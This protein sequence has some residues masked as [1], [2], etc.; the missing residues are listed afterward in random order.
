MSSLNQITDAALAAC[1]QCVRGTPHCPGTRGCKQA[2]RGLGPCEW[3]GLSSKPLDSHWEEAQS[4]GACTLLAACSHCISSCHSSNVWASFSIAN[5]LT[6][7]QHVLDS[8]SR[9][10]RQSHHI[11]VSED[12]G[13]E[14]VA[15]HYTAALLSP[16]LH[17][18]IGFDAPV[19]E[20]GSRHGRK[21]F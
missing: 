17:Q 11:S 2:V 3:S 10:W 13:H 21:T 19:A 16:W 7:P 9:F 12:L 15:V 8:E 18:G 4:D 20:I 14:T 1:A 6:A 5:I